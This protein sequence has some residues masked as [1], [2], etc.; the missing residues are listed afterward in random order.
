MREPNPITQTL[1]LWLL[2]LALAVI[3]ISQA[4][5]VAEVIRERLQQPTVTTTKR[6]TL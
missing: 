3:G 1:L 2:Y 5:K 6:V 4:P